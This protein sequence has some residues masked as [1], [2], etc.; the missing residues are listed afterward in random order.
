MAEKSWGSSV[1]G[2]EFKDLAVVVLEVANGKAMFCQ[3][4]ATMGG[5]VQTIAERTVD[6]RIEDQFT[7]VAGLG[8]DEKAATVERRIGIFDDAEMGSVDENA[9]DSVAIKVSLLPIRGDPF[10]PLRAVRLGDVKIARPSHRSTAQ[11]VVGELM[12]RAKKDETAETNW[13]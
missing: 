2:Y 3:L 6:I 7:G 13:K 1:L 12:N 10:L 9:R 11:E 8:E 4:T 5:I